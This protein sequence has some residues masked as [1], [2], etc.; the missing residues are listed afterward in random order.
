MSPLSQGVT[1]IGLWGAL[2]AGLSLGMMMVT[3]APSGAAAAGSGDGS[4]TVQVIRDVNWN[5]TYDKALESG[6]QGIKVTLTDD[7]GNSLSATTNAAGTVT[8][9][10]ATSPLKGGKYRVQ[11]TIPS[12]LSYL[13]PVPAGGPAPTLSPLVDFVDVRG[14]TKASLSMGVGDPGDYSQADPDVATSVHWYEKNTDADPSMTAMYRWPYSRRGDTTSA[15][16]TG[17][18]TYAQIGTT[19]GLAYKRSSKLLF[20][21]ALAKR[22][23]AYGPAGSGG[24][25][26]L[27]G[28]GQA[29]VFAKLTDAG[30]TAHRAGDPFHDEDFFDTPGKE[31]LG[32]LEI[33]SDDKTLYAVNLATRSLVWFDVSK[34]RVN[35]P[36]ASPKGQVAIP[37]PGCPASGDWSPYGL[38]FHNGKVY[39]GGVYSGESTQKVSDM[40]LYVLAYTPGGGSP[41]PVYSHSLDY[42]RGSDYTG[43]PTNTKGLTAWNPWYSAWDT[44][45]WHQS[46]FT[47]NFN[48]PTPILSDIEFDRDGS[49]ILGFRDRFGDQLGANGG[50]TDTADEQ[51]YSVLGTG[52][53]LERA[54][55]NGSGWVW[56]GD[57]GCP[58]NNTGTNQQKKGT[59][60][61][62]F[63]AGTWAQLADAVHGEIAQGGI[64]YK[65]RFSDTMTTLLDPLGQIN[66]AGVGVVSNSDGTYGTDNAARGYTLRGPSTFDANTRLTAR[67]E[68][69]GGFGKA[70]GLGDLELLADPAPI[71]IGDRVWYDK[72]GDGIQDPSEPPLAGVTVT[73]KDS[74]GKVIATTKTDA[75]GEYFFSDLSPDTTYKVCFDAS[76]A[77]NLPPGV[78]ASDLKPTK[79]A[80]GSN[81]A[82]D[83]NIDR[84]G[85]LTA[86]TTDIGVADHT[87]DAGFTVPRF[88]LAIRVKPGP[89]YDKNGR[90]TKSGKVCPCGRTSFKITVSNRGQETAKDIKVSVRVP[91]GTRLLPG[92]WTLS[93][94]V[95]TKTIAGPLKPGASVTVTLPLKV[96]CGYTGSS[97][98]AT[99]KIISWSDTSGEIRTMDAN[100]HNNTST[101]VVKVGCDEKPILK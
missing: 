52:G 12:A 21:G 81:A 65:P 24:I 78:T 50:S 68:P 33:S 92:G 45:K 63:Y 43:G 94:G 64:A 77:T 56:Q 30:N 9:N 98:R 16:P 36:L 39:I 91:A 25:Y 99:G 62:E 11:A 73:L 90:P 38:G 67:A 35:G 5:G 96:E 93:G 20:A 89:S 19:Y 7:A 44:A 1:G 82:I 95:A 41:A 46:V 84:T 55:A 88:D 59:A 66:T 14:G 72:D 40:K 74:T 26:V 27:D 15:R 70:N 53:A 54:C 58:D 4:V 101:G 76:T 23:A 71:Q 34:A 61:K 100:T 10:P 75:K 13:T 80:A 32:D 85:C 49:L 18:A 51:V 2:P 42:L 22:H 31:G 69:I 29:S 37:D 28:S 83:S 87:Y 48:Y 6:Q 57:P 3:G 86:K 60:A 47:Q 79:Q 97:I 17:I 8:F